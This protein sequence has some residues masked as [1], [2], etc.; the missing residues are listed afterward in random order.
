[1]GFYKSIFKNKIVIAG[2]SKGATPSYLLPP[3][4][5]NAKQGYQIYESID[6]ICEGEVEGLVGQHGKT[7]IG[8]RARKAFNQEHLTIGHERERLC[9][10]AKICAEGNSRETI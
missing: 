7:L 5:A 9:K 1:M 4:A 6:L 8:T 2:R 3:S 10:L